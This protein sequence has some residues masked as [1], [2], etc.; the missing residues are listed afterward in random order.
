MPSLDQRKPKKI[1]NLRTDRPYHWI[2]QVAMKDGTHDNRRRFCTLTAAETKMAE[3]VAN[4]EVD[5]VLLLPGNCNPKDIHP[6]E[7]YNRVEA[8]P[9]TEYGNPS[10]TINP[11]RLLAHALEACK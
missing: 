8:Q 5:C 1:K 10:V 11:G 3:I 4:P 9:F 2:L 7:I 6:D